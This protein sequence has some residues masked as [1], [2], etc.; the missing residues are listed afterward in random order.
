MNQTKS[1]KS[2]VIMDIMNEARDKVDTIKE[3]SDN[4]QKNTDQLL[5]NNHEIMDEVVRLED[6][7]SSDSQPTFSDHDSFMSALISIGF[8]SEQIQQ[9]LQ[10]CK[11]EN[12]EPTLQDAVDSLINQSTDI[13][14]P[15]TNVSTLPTAESNTY[16]MIEA[17]IPTVIGHNKS[18]TYPVSS[19]QAET[20][21]KY[22]PSPS[23]SSQDKEEKEGFYKKLRQEKENNLKH[24]EKIKELIR[25][26][27]NERRAYYPPVNHVTQP[28]TSLDDESELIQMQEAKEMSRVSIRLLNGIIIT[29]FFDPTD[30]LEFVLDW[31]Q[32]EYDLTQITL[33]QSF[34]KI[35]YSAA[36]MTK[37][38]ITL[39]FK[40]GGSLVVKKQGAVTDVFG[41]SSDA[42][43]NVAVPILPPVNAQPAMPLLANLQAAHDWG[44]PGSILGGDFITK[45]VFL[46]NIETKKYIIKQLGPFVEI[47]SLRELSF[48]ILIRRAKVGDLPHLNNLSP[49]EGQM[50]LAR[51]IRENILSPKLIDMFIGC[52]MHTI[53]LTSCNL[54]TNELLH[55]ITRI[56]SISKLVIKGSSLLTDKA[57][58][59]I[60]EM[61]HL[62]NLILEN[63][64]NL[65][66]TSCSLISKLKKL[67]ILNL[68]ATKV[69][70]KGVLHL[71]NN[72]GLVIIEELNLSKTSITQNILL[73]LGKHCHNLKV[74]NLDSTKVTSLPIITESTE[75]SLEKLRELDFSNCDFRD[76]TN[77]S[78]FFKCL[79]LKVLKVYDASI[80]D[81]SFLKYLPLESISF[82]RVIQNI[83][84][85]SPFNSL[86]HHKFTQLNLTNC[87]SLDLID[88]KCIGMIHT[89]TE[90]SLK[91]CRCIESIALKSIVSLS[92]LR[93]LDLEHTKLEDN[94]AI[95]IFPFLSQLVY[96][97]L[98]GTQISNLLLQS[99]LLNKCENL[100]ILNLNYTKVNNLGL[101]CLSIPYLSSLFLNGTNANEKTEEIVLQNCR[102]LKNLTLN[103]LIS[104]TIDEDD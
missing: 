80:S 45:S 7:M 26:D 84:G 101:S 83:D 14:D 25:N 103:N 24:K 3:M 28:D 21:I 35:E 71:I 57:V 58:S 46:K 17:G 18:I 19:S 79:N 22:L 69:S 55:R 68:R 81:F 59:F 93:I 85:S 90:L 38:L 63:C 12:I 8:Q 23:H 89:L 10:S 74:L 31:I 11:R 41:R 62:N 67:K 70:D 64:S 76:D 34:P 2:E 60:A 40:K 9:Y 50:I 30:T 37:S 36:D 66:N 65:T 82:P 6:R 88:M 53:D 1:E 97:N 94:T 95:Y 29:K 104:D 96:L 43:S 47:V 27:R 42:K 61:P 5:E 92:Q 48:R 56:K 99:Q 77:F 91:N 73:S 13:T 100:A 87:L 52:K 102:N 44:D 4:F 32:N 15:I 78:E 51:L 39:G 72:E 86:Q 33:T 49:G 16:S 20:P 98:S 54:I 75:F